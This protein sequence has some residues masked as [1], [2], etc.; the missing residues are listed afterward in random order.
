MRLIN[1]QTLT[2]KE[3]YGSKIPPYAILTH[4]W[5]EG[6][7]ITYQDWTA[8]ELGQNDAASRKKGLQKILRTCEQAVADRLN[9]VWVDTNCIDKRSSSELTEAINSMFAYYRDAEIC[10]AYMADVP[11][12]SIDDTELSELFCHSRWFTRGWTLQELLAPRKLIFYSQTWERIGSKTGSSNAI[13]SIT[14]IDVSYLCGQTDLIMASVAKKMSW[15]STRT[16][17][18]VEDIAYC[19]LGLFDINMPLLYGEGT[20]AF[21]RLQEEIIRSCH[22]HTIFCWTW[23]SS[24]PQNWVSML[25]PFPQTFKDSSNYVKR[26]RLESLAPYSTT[27]LGLSISLPVISGLTNLFAV[28]DAGLAQEQFSRRVCICLRRAEHRSTVFEKMP[29]PQTPLTLNFHEPHTLHRYQMLIQSATSRS[30][31]RLLSQHLPLEFGLVFFLEPS[32]TQLSEPS[33]ATMAGV[34]ANRPLETKYLEISAVPEHMFDQSRNL[35]TIPPSGNSRPSSSV[36]LLEISVSEDKSVCEIYYLFFMVT[37]QRDEATW[38]CL[39]TTETG[40]KKYKLLRNPNY[41]KYQKSNLLDSSEVFKHLKAEALHRWDRGRLY[42]KDRTEDRLFLEIGDHVKLGIGS[43]IRRAVLSGNRN[44]TLKG[45]DSGAK[46][47][48]VSDTDSISPQ[49]NRA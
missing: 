41:S 43:E 42:Q 9:W 22:D 44:I 7:E 29:F 20:K 32:A 12:T 17:T 46:E 48:D 47:E 39:A 25:A 26:V 37:K 36:V 28:L 13:S 40:L 30:P 38:S 14:G 10:Y 27:N 18:R 5:D 11:S 4:T 31:P 23:N 8:W 21:T 19:M 35:L 24:V 16:T 2:L 1:A 34:L 3:F 49:I 15:L 33:D 45:N 6:E